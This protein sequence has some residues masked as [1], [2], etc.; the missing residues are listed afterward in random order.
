M[1]SGFVELAD[2]PLETAP[3]GSAIRALVAASGGS[4]AHF[5]F[6]PGQTSTAVRHKRVDELWYVIGG[7]GE[8]WLC[9]DGQETLVPVRP[10]VA[11]RILVGTSFQF[12]CTTQALEIVL[13]TL[14]PWQGADDAERVDGPW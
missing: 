14:P 11:V 6:Q 12:R 10:G 1:K 2:A 4:L 9:E 7:E 13:T 3:D 5:T 8:L